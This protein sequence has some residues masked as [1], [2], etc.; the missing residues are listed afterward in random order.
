M[1]ILVFYLFIYLF[2]LDGLKGSS[3]E[4]LMYKYTMLHTWDGNEES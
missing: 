4:N 1:A 3:F 2:I